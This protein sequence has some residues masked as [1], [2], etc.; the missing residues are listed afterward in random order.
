METEEKI[1][2][3]YQDGAVV[4]PACADWSNNEEATA[5]ALPDGFTCD[6][7]WQFIPAE[8]ENKWERKLHD[9]LDCEG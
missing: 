8:E 7:C 3:Y 2:A 6:S 9:E 4:C 1:I 5:E